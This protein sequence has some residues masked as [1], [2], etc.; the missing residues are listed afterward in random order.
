MVVGGETSSSS[1]LADAEADDN[2]PKSLSVT[3]AC[4][5]ELGKVRGGGTRDALAVVSLLAP[6]LPIEG[7]R[8]LTM[9]VFSKSGKAVRGEGCGGGGCGGCGLLLE[10]ALGWSKVLVDGDRGEEA[11]VKP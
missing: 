1:A 9:G 5:K 2:N 6:V 4:C 3:G 8:L 10:D 11:M 7:C